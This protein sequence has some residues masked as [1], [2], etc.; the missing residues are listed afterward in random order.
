MAFSSMYDNFLTH[1]GLKE[2]LN[3]G[4]EQSNKKLKNIFDWIKNIL[5]KK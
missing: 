1:H 3:F 2:M 4:P 5:N